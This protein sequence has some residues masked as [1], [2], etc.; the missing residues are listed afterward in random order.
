MEPITAYILNLLE[1]IEKELK[2]LRIAATKTLASLGCI[3]IGLFLMWAGLLLLAW[4]FF[5]ALSSL[6]GPVLAGLSTSVLILLG[7]GVFLWI[8]RKNLR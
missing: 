7:G 4:T 5:T 3:V 8:S 6:L 2:L 1:I